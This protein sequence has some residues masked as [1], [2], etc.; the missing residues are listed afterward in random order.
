[1]LIV[2]CCSV[3]LDVFNQNLEGIIL[4]DVKMQALIRHMMLNAFL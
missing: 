4:K 1:M 2:L 3:L